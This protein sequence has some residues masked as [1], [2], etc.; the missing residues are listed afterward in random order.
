MSSRYTSAHQRMLS[1]LKAPVRKR[2]QGEALLTLEDRARKL[3]EEMAPLDVPFAMQVVEHFRNSGVYSGK[4]WAQSYPIVFPFADPQYVDHLLSVRAEDRIGSQ[5]HYEL[6]R[7]LHD[8]L[9][10]CPESNSGVA[11]SSSNLVRAMSNFGV[12]VMGKLGMKSAAGHTDFC[13]WINAM[14][15][16]I[17]DVLLNDS[18]L[19]DLYWDADHLRKSIARSEQGDQ[20]SASDLYRLVCFELIYKMFNGE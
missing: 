1:L 18:H 5:F 4:I 3:A 19:C 2:L 11:P 14:Q 13:A 17:E 12:R 10:R 20:S 6:L 15:P 8:G 7:R 9:Y 16:S